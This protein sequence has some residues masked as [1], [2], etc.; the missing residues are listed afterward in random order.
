MTFAV[1]QLSLPSLFISQPFEAHFLGHSNDAGTWHQGNA[2]C[3]NAVKVFLVLYSKT[4]TE[5]LLSKPL[6]C[7]VLLTEAVAAELSVL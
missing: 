4:K 6:G 2:A 7:S 1:L 5:L 3:E